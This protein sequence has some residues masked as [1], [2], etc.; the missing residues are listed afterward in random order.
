MN[1]TTGTRDYATTSIVLRNLQPGSENRY[2]TVAQYDAATDSLIA[3]SDVVYWDGTTNA[4]SAEW[5]TDDWWETSLGLA[6]LTVGTCGPVL[7]GCVGLLEQGEKNRAT[8]RA[9]EER[10]G[11]K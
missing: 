8:K 10:K 11:R 2:T 4:P 5:P 3:S 7:L 1:Q 6:G 9:A